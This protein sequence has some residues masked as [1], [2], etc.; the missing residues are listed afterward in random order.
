[1]QKS[2]VEESVL[3]ILESGSA[4]SWSDRPLVH[5]TSKPFAEKSSEEREEL[6]GRI[7]EQLDLIGDNYCF[8]PSVEKRKTEQIEATVTGAYSSW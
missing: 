2:A 7:A 6:Y 4:P 5:A 8:G 3:R 1:M